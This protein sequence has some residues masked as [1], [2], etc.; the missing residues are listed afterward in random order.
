MMHWRERLAQVR[1][2]A[3]YALA[4]ARDQRLA[5]VAASLTFSSVLSLVPLVAV[6]LSVMTAFPVFTD[7]RDS[8]SR[9]VAGTLLPVPYAQTIVRYLTEF[10]AKAA[11]VGIAGLLFL[12]LSALS[13]ML[14]VDRV[15]NDI[16]RVHRR[17]S[18]MQRLLVYWAVLSVGPL[19]LGLSLTLTSWVISL[20]DHHGEHLESGFRHVIGILAPALAVVAY[21]SVYSLVPNRRVPWRDALVGGAMT[22]LTGE[23]MSRG[24]AA[25]VL[26]GRLMSV[27]GA[28][29]ALP[30]FLMWIFLS[31][32]AF[33]LGAVIAANVSTLGRI[34]HADRHRPGDAWVTAVAILKLLF[35]ARAGGALGAVTQR[36]MARQLLSDEE[37]L[38]VLLFTLEECG[39]VRHLG[40]KPVVPVAAGAVGPQT[41]AE[42]GIPAVD[43]R[44]DPGSGEW[45]LACDPDR[46]SLAPAYD[47][48]ALDPANTLLARN[49]I[50]VREW[51][52]PM[53]ASQW[54][55]LTLAQLA[56]G[57]NRAT[58]SMPWRSSAEPNQSELSTSRSS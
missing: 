53:H 42:P 30:V 45:V 50:G 46:T 28:F 15:L 33:L 36:A 49:L 52:A 22:A 14:T 39:Y 25:Y 24:F 48:F 56:G 20:S 2:M 58:S 35:E 44:E 27:Y 47:R 6:V 57:A 38:S 34:R 41:D 23:L 37:D 17:R 9:D 29:A 13:M 10:A 26:H 5:E 21:S 40:P 7:F 1:E 31:W 55:S 32:L 51:F 54:R 3:G 8:L 16:W 18:L 19:L 12:G 11:G 43:E 4:T